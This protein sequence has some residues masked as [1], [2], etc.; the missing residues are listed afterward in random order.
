M[1]EYELQRTVLNSSVRLLTK[2]MPGARSISLCAL[3]QAGSR[4]EDEEEHGLSHLLEHVIFKGTGKMNAREIAEA[5]DFI[6]A[7]INAATSKEYTT[8]YTRVMEEYMDRAVEIIIDMISDPLF[9]SGDLESE[10]KVVL[11]EIN[12]YMDSPDEMVHDFLAQT[13]W[14][15]H[16]LGHNILGSEEI[17]DGVSTNN[18]RGFF[19]QRYVGKRIVFVGSGS[20]NHDHIAELLQR[21]LG[22]IEQGTGTDRNDSF[23]PLKG[24]YIH[25][26]DTEQAHIAIGS[27]GLPGGHPDRFALH[28]MDNILG[29]SM[30]SRL[31]QKIREELGL[32]YS[33]YS[34]SSMFV[35]TG[36]VGIYCGTHPDNARKVLET[37]TA[38]L[39]GVHKSG[40]KTEELE[41][42]KNHI[43]GSL[44]ISAENSSNV[45]NRI[46][47]SEILGKEQLTIDE[48][49]QRVENVTLDD[50]MRVFNET[51]GGKKTSLAVV[52]P[53]N[54]G[55]LCL[56]DDI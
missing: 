16:P 10:K 47:K 14:G 46:A 35:D 55:D 51:W 40:F 11:E 2:K 3:I 31:F 29:G 13:I 8:V 50:A 42:S 49:I 30:S 54:D 17:I 53:L 37:I 45:M 7:D 39:A 27:I 33:I 44:L 5:F 20:I 15:N 52:G 9:D 12:M 21:R 4:D 23:E 28:I 43:K 19:K 36:M 56:P 1:T 41:R 25:N 18:L 38:E 6:G 48:V 24:V 32:V 26:K 34:Y 22:G